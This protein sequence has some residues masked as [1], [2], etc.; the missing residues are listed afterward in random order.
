[1]WVCRPGVCWV[2][3]LFCQ[4]Q[5]CIGAF[6]DSLIAR[7]VRGVKFI[8]SDDHAG[9]K[10]ARKAMF[11]DVPW[12]RC[13]F[14]LQHNAQ[15][16]VSNTDQRAVVALQICSIFSVPDVHETNRLLNIAIE[17]WSTAHPKLAAWA[18]EKILQGFVT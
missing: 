8:A 18:Q 9:L 14:Y 10:A 1:M 6:I 11:P 12:Q 15:G 3:R 16:Y 5:K 17:L 13:Q 4:T 7:G 2:S